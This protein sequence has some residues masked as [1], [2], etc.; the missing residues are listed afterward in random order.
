MRC[1]L[2]LVAVILCPVLADEPRAARDVRAVLDAQVKAWNKGD[3]DGF[4]DG[5][6]DDDRLTFYSGGDINKGLKAVRERYHK[7]YKA[8]GKEM[9]TLSFSDLDIQVVA[10]DFAV[11][12]GR[13]RLV[14][15]KDEPTGLFTLWMRKLPGGWKVIHDH[16]SAGEKK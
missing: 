15:K 9:G 1:S 6:W 2:L 5:Y 11:V 10:A 12:R 16:T 8:E 4:L 13:Y 14:M 7:R 3:L